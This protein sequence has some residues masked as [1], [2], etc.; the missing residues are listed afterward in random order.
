MET[1]VDKG[2]H[3]PRKMSCTVRH[4]KRF[5]ITG[6]CYPNEHYMVDISSRISHLEELIDAGH[7]LTINRGRQFGKT[8]LYFN[9]MKQ[10]RDKYIPFS[11]TFEGVEDNIFVSPDTLAYAIVEKMFKNIKRIH[12]DEAVEIAKKVISDILDKY[13]S[14]KQMSFEDFSDFVSELCDESPKPIV[15]II[16][17]G[18]NASNYDSF[19]S[20]LGLF[21]SAFL[22]RHEYPTFQSVVLTGVYDIRN[23]TYKDHKYPNSPYNIATPLEIDMTF[24]SN[25]IKQM[26]DDYENDHQTSMNTS[27]IAQMIHDHTGGYPFLVSKLCNIIDE[28]IYGWN[29]EGVMAAINE[30]L[31]EKITL[32]TE[33]YNLMEEYPTLKTLVKDVLHGQHVLFSVNIPE[34]KLAATFNWFADEHGSVKIANRIFEMWLKNIFITE[35]HFIPQQR[36]RAS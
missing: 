4:F 25:E 29:T 2:E 10:L 11:I 5:N 9:L 34:I 18:D 1:I 32:F 36:L 16:D 15:L 19:I 7:Y 35:N 6:T 3:E 8:T 30:L 24:S 27:M 26:L 23:L 14:N 33:F 31:S 28:N 17:E 12:D 21:R 20:L 22:R 13:S